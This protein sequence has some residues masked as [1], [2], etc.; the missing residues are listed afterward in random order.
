[1]NWEVPAAIILVLMLSVEAIL[2]LRPM[3]KPASSQ[4]DQGSPI[5]EG[6]DERASK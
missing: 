2:T 1:M 5:K 6:V 3:L 4:P